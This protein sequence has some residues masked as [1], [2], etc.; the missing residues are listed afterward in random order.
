MK[1]RTYSCRG[2]SLA[3]QPK[4]DVTTS[5][6][7]NFAE[8]NESDFMERTL[9]LIK[10]E[11]VKRAI[12]GRI[13]SKLEDAGLKIVAMKMIVPDRKLAEAH[14]P[15]D[16]EWCEA[17]WKKT[18]EAYDAKGQKL[19]LNAMELGKK[20]RGN[21]INH[22][23]NKPIIAM[24]LEGNGAISFTRKIVG[25]TSPEKADPSTI[26]GSFSIDSYANA[27]R[28]GRPVLNLVHASDSVKTAESEIRVWFKKNEIFDYK[29]AQQD[30]I[31]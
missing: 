17:L 20:I 13:I 10:P 5:T 29:T 12:S 22:I 19:S 30:F 3:L 9:V 16:R 15:L 14:Y 18:K 26:R 25:A 31:Y 2:G 28:N 27:D 7:I 23:S 4:E 1:P 21:L 11:A 24:V 8:H 6:S